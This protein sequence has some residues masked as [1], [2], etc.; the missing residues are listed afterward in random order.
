M[1]IVEYNQMY[2]HVKC[3]G[4][5]E[6]LVSCAFL[7]FVSMDFSLYMVIVEFSH[8]LVGKN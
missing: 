4:E 2:E 7:V 8:R 3:T 6:Q 1:S 5:R